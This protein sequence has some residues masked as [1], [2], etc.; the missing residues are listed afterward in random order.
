[1]AI[2]AP[3]IIVE[4]KGLDKPRAMKK[5][6]SMDTLVS[7]CLSTKMREVIETADGKQMSVAQAMVDKLINIALF[8]ESNSD[9]LKAIK[10][11]LDRIIGKPAVANQ[12]DVIEIPRI[13]FALKD[14][15]SP[16]PSDAI[17]A[18]VDD[19]EMIL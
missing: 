14:N 16:A 12:E 3:P 7:A 6:F 2:K 15:P 18:K 19:K 13:I 8:A 10:E 11:S 17:V 1:M 4:T 9:S 5:N